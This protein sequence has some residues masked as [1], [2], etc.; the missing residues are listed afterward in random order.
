MPK[1]IAD[2]NLFREILSNKNLGVV[3]LKKSINRKYKAGKG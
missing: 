1:L 2:K 3:L